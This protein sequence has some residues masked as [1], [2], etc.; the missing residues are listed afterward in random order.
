MAERKAVPRFPGMTWNYGQFP[1]C[2]WLCYMVSPGEV[3]ANNEAKK[4][5][6][7]SVKVADNVNYR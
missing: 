7:E 3:V 5:K 2:G 6:V 1:A 4:L